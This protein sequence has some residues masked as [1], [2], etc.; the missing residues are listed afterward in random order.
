MIALAKSIIHTSQMVDYALQESK[1]CK[2]LQH[3]YCSGVSGAE[4]NHEFKMFQQFNGRCKNNTISIVLSPKRIDGREL[5]DKELREISNTY[6]AKMNLQENQYI[7]IKHADR[8]NNH[9]HII[10]NRIDFNGV[11]YKDKHIGYKSQKIGIEIAAE[12]ELINP[13]DKEKENQKYRDKTPISE[14]NEK[15]EIKKIKKEILEIHT[16]VI[17]SLN[18]HSF[19]GYQEK[20]MLKNVKINPTINK[21]GEP[22][23][24]RLEYKGN[25]FKASEIHRTALS[26]K[27][28]AGD[29]LR[30]GEDNFFIQSSY[31]QQFRKIVQEREEKPKEV[32]IAPGVKNKFVKPTPVTPEKGKKTKREKEMEFTKIL[33][34]HLKKG[35]TQSFLKEVKPHNI[36]YP[37]QFLLQ[38]IVQNKSIPLAEAIKTL[39]SLRVNKERIA[40]LIKAPKIKQIEKPK[41]KIKSS[42]NISSSKKG[43]NRSK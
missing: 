35:D 32:K 39:Q 13:R 2:I 12:E 29:N 14:L 41:G 6:M 5:T 25:D 34:N 31:K 27:K 7:A 28:M 21:Q 15:E 24:F 22:Q 37:E 8:E 33:V 42:L 36:Q 9:V 4:I 20:M 38:Y 18:V 10:A 1:D 11:A 3:N 17:A 26:V 19:K 23:G 40:E 43:K 30:K 16:N